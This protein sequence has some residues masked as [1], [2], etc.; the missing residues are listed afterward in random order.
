MVNL[1]F[2]L[3]RLWSAHLLIFLGKQRECRDVLF[4]FFVEVRPGQ[5]C[6][7]IRPSHLGMPLAERALDEFIVLHNRPRAR[8]SC[9]LRPTAQPG[10][11]ALFP[12][13]GGRDGDLCGL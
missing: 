13:F 10:S 2:E 4:Q 9:L 12:A 3:A 5:Q 6:E 8:I 7:Q 1:V 11:I